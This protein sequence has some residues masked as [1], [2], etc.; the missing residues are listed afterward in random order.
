MLDIGWNDGC[1]FLIVLQFRVSEICE[2]YQ[3]VGIRMLDEMLSAIAIILYFKFSES[4]KLSILE[5]IM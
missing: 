3:V 5:S 4:L 1:I 2:S